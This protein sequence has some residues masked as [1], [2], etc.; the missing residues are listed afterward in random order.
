MLNKKLLV[1]ILGIFL[2]LTSACDRLEIADG[3]YPNYEHLSASGE[4]GNWIP[5]FIPRSAIDIRE[6][7][8]IDTGSELLTFYFEKDADFSLDGFCERVTAKDTILPPS[9]F[10]DVTWWPNSLF[11]GVGENGEKGSY[12]FYRCERQAFLAVI[13]VGS[14]FQAFYWRISL[15]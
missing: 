5:T 9:G 13:Q 1:I 2:V 3:Y 14:R 15:S 10:L 8:K 11:H 7:H 4:P 6:R 12:E